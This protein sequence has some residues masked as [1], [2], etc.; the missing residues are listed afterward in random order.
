MLSSLPFRVSRYGV[1]RVNAATS[2][3]VSG[4]PSLVTDGFSVIS[5]LKS[6]FY[7]SITLYLYLN[8]KIGDKLLYMHPDML[9]CQTGPSMWTIGPDQPVIPGVAF[10]R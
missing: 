6:I 10:I 7:L 3:G 8:E 9:R 4:L 5:R 2:H 1:N